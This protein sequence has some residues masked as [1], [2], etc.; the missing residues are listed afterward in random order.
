MHPAGVEAPRFQ[1]GVQWPEGHCSLRKRHTIRAAVEGGRLRITIDNGDGRGA[2]DYTECV[3][4]DGPVTIQRALNKPSR[5]T[6]ELLCGDGGPGAPE[7][8]GRVVVTGEAGTVLFTGYLATEPV[9]VY[10]GET[11]TGAVTGRGSVR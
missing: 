3:V 11:T 6:A 10:A 1:S 5:C 8:L 7:R 9:Q 2:V 4:S